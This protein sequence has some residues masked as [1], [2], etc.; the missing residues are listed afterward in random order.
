MNGRLPDAASSTGAGTGRPAH[1]VI[2]TAWN[3]R[4][5]LEDAIG[6][7]Y[8]TTAAPEELAV[9]TNFRD[10]R[11][12]RRV[13]GH[14]GRWILS[15]VDRLG[16]MVCDGLAAT[17]AA[18]VSLLDDDDVYL[19]GRLPLAREAFGADPSL[20]FLHVGS[21]PFLRERP[22]STRTPRS[23]APPAVLT[24][25]MRSR[26]D[27][28]SVWSRGAAFNG[29]SVTFRRDFIVPHLA[30]LASIR[31]A[32]PPYLFYR[33]WAS[34]WGLRVEPR[35]LVGV[36]QH[37]SSITRG[38][39]EHRSVR[40]PQLRS[41]SP[42]LAADARSIQ[43][44]LPPGTWNRSLQEMM[45]MHSV[46][47]SI[48]DASVPRR[49]VAGAAFDLVQRRK[50]WVPRSALLGLA[51]CRMVSPRLGRIAYRVLT[52]PPGA[53]ARRGTEVESSG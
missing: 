44:F 14:G 29:S 19:P 24:T 53:S 48:D 32:V 2:I 11:L 15:E 52:A 1:A 38:S 23:R 31:L 22:P 47:R 27:F 9:V 20:G 16:H 36:G 26:S 46:F 49:T 42:S 28:R 6:S 18:V 33:A 10:A 30:E 40:L 7:V 17:A 8:R 37:P 43:S 35:I 4:E 50:V 34:S 45:A 3:R 41:I 21:V 25:Q 39:L 12:E 5:Y 51:A 13:A